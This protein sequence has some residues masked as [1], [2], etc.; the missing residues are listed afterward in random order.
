[1]QTIFKILHT[2]RSRRWL[3]IHEEGSSREDILH[4][5]TA[6]GV[7]SKDQTC[8]VKPQDIRRGLSQSYGHNSRIIIIK[9]LGLLHQVHRIV[10]S[11]SSKRYVKFIGLL[12]TSRTSSLC[13]SEQHSGQL[14]F[15]DY[16]HRHFEPIRHSMSN[17]SRRV[18]NTQAR[19][20]R[21][22]TETHTGDAP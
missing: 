17:S 9:F 16:H 6:S 22:D 13:H 5:A 2:L 3:F 1:M 15:G 7:T 10:T 14:R 20:H 8:H 11:S 12:L 19:H 4:A 21:D 18:G